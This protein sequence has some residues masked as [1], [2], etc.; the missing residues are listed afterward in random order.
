MSATAL[1]VRQV[2]FRYLAAATA[3]AGCPAGLLIPVMILLMQERGLSLSQIG[4]VVTAQG[5]VVLALE[6]PTGGLADALGRA[7]RCWSPPGLLNLAL[8]GAVRG[9]RLRSGLFFA[10]LRAAGGLPRARQRPARVLVRRRDARR[11]P[12]RRVRARPRPRRHR[13]RRAPS[14][15]GALLSGGLVALGPVG[16]VSALTVPVL[17]A[18]VLQ[19]VAVVAPADAAGRGPARAGDPGRCAPR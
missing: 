7:S 1:S 17:V 6:L 11:R 13:H 15:A 10:G 18:V 2:R 8:A 16:P 14:R 9:G 19:A 12:R 4:L 3:C 5:L